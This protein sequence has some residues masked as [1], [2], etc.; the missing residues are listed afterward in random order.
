MVNLVLL[1]LMARLDLL[2]L[3]DQKGILVLQVLWVFPALA[4]QWVFQVKRVNVVASV[5]LVL[6]VPQAV[7]ETKVLRVSWAPS[8]HPASP[9]KREILVHQDLLASL[10]PTE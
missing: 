5:K 2:V 9:P 1:A 10:V 4:D 8:V 7:R 3:A 6:R